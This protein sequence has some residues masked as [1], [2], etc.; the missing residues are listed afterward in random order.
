M[1]SSG[2]QHL[3]DFTLVPPLAVYQFYKIPDKTVGRLYIAAEKMLLAFHKEKAD[4]IAEIEG[5]VREWKALQEGRLGI[6]VT[7]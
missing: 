5:L 7:Y 6:E 4:E 2:L 1:R 3:D